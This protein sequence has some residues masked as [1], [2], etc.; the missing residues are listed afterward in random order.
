MQRHTGGAVSALAFSGE[1]LLLSGA[2][3]GSVFV[4]EVRTGSLRHTLAESTQ[5]I[6]AVVVSPA[7]PIVRALVCGWASPAS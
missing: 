3:D 4:H 1:Q 6:E 2:T 5:P 7:L